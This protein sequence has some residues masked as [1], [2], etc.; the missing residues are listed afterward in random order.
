MKKEGRF[1]AAL[2]IIE[3][4]S[5]K[6]RLA[7]GRRA[8]K[9]ERRERKVAQNGKDENDGANDDAEAV[10][11]GAKFRAG[12]NEKNRKREKSGDRERI[13]AK[14]GEKIACEQ[15]AQG[16]RRTATGA[17]DSGRFAENTWG[18]KRRQNA[19]VAIDG[20]DEEREHSGG[21]Q[22]DETG[23]GKTRKRHKILAPLLERSSENRVE[24]ALGSDARKTPPDVKN[25]PEIK[26][27]LTLSGS[28]RIARRNLTNGKLAPLRGERSRREVV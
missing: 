13:I 17:I 28:V 18:R 23:E 7:G 4:I 27:L 21:A 6:A 19:R 20:D 1:R 11:N 2:I 3:K 9:V 25:G 15:R 24:V 10:I 16:P 26:R 8:Q 12:E 22:N 14:R 5:K